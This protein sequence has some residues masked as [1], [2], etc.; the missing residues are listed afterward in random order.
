MR[1]VRPAGV[2]TV[3]AVGEAEPT[4]PPASRSVRFDQAA[5]GTG[6]GQAMPS[7][8]GPKGSPGRAAFVAQRRIP[9]DGFSARCDAGAF[10]LCGCRSVSKGKTEPS[11]SD[12]A[13]ACVRPQ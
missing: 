1:R 13:R 12:R 5:T 6:D 8:I 2:E 4:G 3:F 10:G 7:G 9:E 11:E